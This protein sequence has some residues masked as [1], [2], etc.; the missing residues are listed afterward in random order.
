MYLIII[1]YYV[2]VGISIIRGG[3]VWMNAVLK[4]M[5]AGGRG[6]SLGLKLELLQLL[7]FRNL[8]QRLLRFHNVVIGLLFGGRRPFL[9]SFRGAKP[10]PRTLEPKPYTPNLKAETPNPKP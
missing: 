2:F 8:P 4:K 6:T 7:D 10:K 3:G 9:G 5:V 1:N